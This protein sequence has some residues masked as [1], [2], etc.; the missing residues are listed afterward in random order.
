M[1][2]GLSELRCSSVRVYSTGEIYGRMNAMKSAI[3]G[4]GRVVIPKPLRDKLGL[5]GGEE[6]EI[7]EENG[8]IEIRPASIDVELVETAEGVVA[9]PK[10]P[11]SVLTAEE[12]RATLDR[13]RR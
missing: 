5:A 4:S 8:A 2:G 1:D 12:V 11:V 10:K 7:T 6:L 13:I 3:D 9:V